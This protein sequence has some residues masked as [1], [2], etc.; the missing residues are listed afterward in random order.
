MKQLMRTA[1][2]M[3]IALIAL[4]ASA[5]TQTTQAQTGE[6]EYAEN[7]F[8]IA[9]Y[10]RKP[11]EET[12]QH[13][14]QILHW[15]R[16]NAVFGAGTSIGI[17]IETRTFNGFN[18]EKRFALTSYGGTIRL[19]PREIG[20]DKDESIVFYIQTDTSTRTFF[21]E[22]ALKVEVFYNRRIVIITH[23]DTGFRRMVPVQR[24]ATKHETDSTHEKEP[25]TA[26][27]FGPLK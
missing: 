16:T 4:A 8:A 14:F 5:A 2:T 27:N 9:W 23:Q 11:A 6:L 15:R 1:K 25:R 20:N 7:M 19:T 13:T 12:P 24:Y 21:P 3:A 22:R 18:S 26:I 10:E 17:P